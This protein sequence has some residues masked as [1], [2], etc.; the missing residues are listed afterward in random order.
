MGPLCSPLK[1]S[2]GKIQKHF[3]MFFQFNPIL[4]VIWFPFEDGESAAPINSPA[5]NFLAAA[6]DCEEIASPENLL[7]ISI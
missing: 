6:S 1:I 5:G 2:A 4:N 7:I 3:G